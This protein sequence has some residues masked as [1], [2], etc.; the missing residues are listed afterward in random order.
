ML[1]NLQKAEAVTSALEETNPNLLISLLA[2]RKLLALLKERVQTFN[3]QVAR[4][5]KGRSPAEDPEIEESLMPMLTTFPPGEEK[6]LTHHQEAEVRKVLDQFQSQ[7][8]LRK[9]EQPSQRTSGSLKTRRR[10]VP[11]L[12]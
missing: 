10:P 11:S 4:Q 1:T 5:S 2:E 12:A 9:S 3:L 6:E 8:H 7:P